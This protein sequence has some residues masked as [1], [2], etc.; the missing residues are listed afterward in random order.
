MPDGA[1]YWYGYENNVVSTLTC[2]YSWRSSATNA[3]IEATKQTNSI[4]FDIWQAYNTGDA[5]T[6]QFDLSNVINMTSYTHAKSIVKTNTSM[7]ARE[8]ITS[9]SRT[10][11]P[12][13]A[14]ATTPPTVAY[15]DTITNNIYDVD[16]S[17]VSSGVIG[18]MNY[19]GGAQNAHYTLTIY[20]SWLE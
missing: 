20:A 2:G 17:S 13:L 19:T 1:V 9:G 8:I 10:G 6:G 7:S 4:V 11:N 5:H 14:W 15:D 18:Y 12:T 16:I 3:N